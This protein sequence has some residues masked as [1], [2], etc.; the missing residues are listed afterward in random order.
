[1]CKKQEKITGLLEEVK[2]EQEKE[3]IVA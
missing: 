2:A 1:M 3:L